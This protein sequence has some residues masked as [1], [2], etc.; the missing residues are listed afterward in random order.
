MKEI[1]LDTY[2][3]YGEVLIPLLLHS[4][5]HERNN[6]S[7]NELLDEAID[8]IRNWDYRAEKNSEEV[9]LARLWVQGVK[10]KYIV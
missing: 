5:R 6:I 10:K 7:N 9:A 4:Y 8:I 1:S 3:L 2:S